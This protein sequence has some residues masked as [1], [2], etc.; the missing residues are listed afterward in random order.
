MVRYAL[1]LVR[2]TRP[3]E[4]QAPEFVMKNVTWG[5]GPRAVQF[6]ILGG[7]ARAL[8]RGNVYV[9]TEDIRAVAHAVMR[10]R[11]FMNFG[12]QAEGYTPDR[13]VDDLLAKFPPHGG[14]LLEDERVRK[15]VNA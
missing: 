11:I 12:A 14:G 15:I 4:P 5:A 13:L 3:S 9:S 10:H 7:K 1:D 8:L 2:K 6:L